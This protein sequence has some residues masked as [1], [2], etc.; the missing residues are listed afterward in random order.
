KPESSRRQ[1]AAAQI[2]NHPAEIDPRIDRGGGGD[3]Y[4]LL[5]IEGAECETSDRAASPDDPGEKTGRAASGHRVSGS[6]RKSDFRPKQEKDA[7]GN[8]KEAQD[9]FRIFELEPGTEV[10]AQNHKNR[11]GDPKEKHQAPAD[12]AAKEEKLGRVA[13]DMENTG[14]RQDLMKV[15]EKSCQRNK[16]DRR[17]KTGDCAR[18]LRQECERKEQQ[19]HHPA[20]VFPVCLKL[21]SYRPHQGKKRRVFSNQRKAAAGASA[22]LRHENGNSSNK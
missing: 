11:A 10:G 13:E 17:A 5:Q 3:K 21:S 20:A 12:V 19:E 9:H 16:E 4:V 6:R 18:D 1:K 8:E 2:N 14:Q 22:I 7:K 15:E